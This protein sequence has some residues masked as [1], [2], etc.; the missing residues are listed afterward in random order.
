[1]KKKMASGRVDS[2][3]EGQYPFYVQAR[4]LPPP[5]VT[6]PPP[7]TTHANTDVLS[8]V[9]STRSARAHMYVELYQMLQ[10]CCWDYCG[11]VV[12]KR[13]T[14]IDF[15]ATN[16]NDAQVTLLLLL[17]LLLLLQLQ[18]LIL[19]LVLIIL[20]LIIIIIIII[21]NDNTTNATYT[22]T[23]TDFLATNYNDGQGSVFKIFDSLKIDGDDRLQWIDTCARAR[24][25][26]ARAAP[27]D[28]RTT[29]ERAARRASRGERKLSPP[30]AAPAR[31]RRWAAIDKDQNNSMDEGEFHQYFGMRQTEYSHRLFEIFDQDFTNCVPM[32][33]F[34]A[35][36]RNPNPNPNPDPSSSSSLGPAS[37]GHEAV[38]GL[39]PFS[40]LLRLR[41][42]TCS[43]S[44]ATTR[45][46]SRSGC[47]RG[48]ARRSTSR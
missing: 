33:R 34:L 22:N 26:A 21:I 41:C 48:A 11:V 35:T 16:Y 24:A 40:S 46:S 15:L 6:A 44:T 38:G 20:I 23:N 37:R 12:P 10:G 9:A 29:R 43:C 47:S 13:L 4:A 31:A 27:I 42:G 39:P 2:L 18:L 28:A 17:L 3:M 7:A 1:M 45:S 36:A 19:I 14:R 25:R 8:L 5:I 30:S 32:K